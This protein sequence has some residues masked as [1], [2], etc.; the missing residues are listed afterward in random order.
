MV[1][2]VSLGIAII[3]ILVIHI[4]IELKGSVAK[5]LNRAI[6]ADCVICIIYLLIWMIWK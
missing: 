3:I 6:I 2:I 5:W 4:V 1:N